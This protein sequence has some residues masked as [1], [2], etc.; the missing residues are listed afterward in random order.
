[1]SFPELDNQIFVYKTEDKKDLN[2]GRTAEKL[3]EVLGMSEPTAIAAACAICCASRELSRILRHDVARDDQESVSVKDLVQC[4]FYGPVMAALA[5][6]TSGT[7]RFRAYIRYNDEAEGR[8][9]KQLGQTSRDARE[10]AELKLMATGG[11]SEK[12]RENKRN[13]AGSS[14]ASNREPAGPVSADQTVP[15]SRNIGSFLVPASYKDPRL[16]SRRTKQVKP[17][18]AKEYDPLDGEY[19]VHATDINSVV[20]IFKTGLVPGALQHET[21]RHLQSL[22]PAQGTENGRTT[23]QFTAISNSKNQF[24]VRDRKDILLVFSGV[25]I[26]ANYECWENEDQP[27]VSSPC[28]IRPDLILAAIT[29]NHVLYE[30]EACPS[31]FVKNIAF[32]WS[33]CLREKDLNLY[34]QGLATTAQLA[35]NKVFKP[36][37]LVQASA[38]ACQRDCGMEGSKRPGLTRGQTSSERISGEYSY[39]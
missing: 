1:M 12:I 28:Q 9:V 31:F 13:S 25:A 8:W 21:A 30:D 36:R 15:S 38:S 32:W 33:K 10:I 5:V 39:L 3:V 17:A 22:V 24:L 35:A 37:K 27:I 11:W 26:A 23:V 18:C 34:D 19:L 4:F 7:S 16:M 2:K 20:S 14:Q 6:K 29:A